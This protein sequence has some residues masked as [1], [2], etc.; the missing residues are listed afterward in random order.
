M[1]CVRVCV[2]VCV[3]VVIKGF[4][5]QYELQVVTHVD[6]AGKL[7]VEAF[8]IYLKRNKTIACLKREKCKT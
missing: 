5:A 7:F 2:C 6:A 4:V 3:C 1:A 8:A